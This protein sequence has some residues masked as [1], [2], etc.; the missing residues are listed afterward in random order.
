M[1]THTLAESTADRQPSLASV[2][3]AAAHRLQNRV[4]T[5]LA[6]H[7]DCPLALANR[8][9]MAPLSAAL[10]AMP[11]HLPLSGARLVDLA[12]SAGMTK[13]AMRQW[14]NECEAWSLIDR[15][16]DT[17]DARNRWIRYTPTGLAWQHAW[18]AATRTAEAE[19]ADELGSA[20]ATV[21]RLGLESYGAVA[22]ES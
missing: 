1:L 16:G 11:G 21:I 14:V 18:H 3:A 9:R 7:P 12:R 6:A 13:Q 15:H 10:S 8:A 17:R 4:A 2:L 20:V 5:L 22:M 19:M